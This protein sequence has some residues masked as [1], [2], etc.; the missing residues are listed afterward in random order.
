MARYDYT[1]MGLVLMFCI[2]AGIIL[3]LAFYEIGVAIF[4]AWD[5]SWLGG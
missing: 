1:R 5:L 2:I 3:G 4:D